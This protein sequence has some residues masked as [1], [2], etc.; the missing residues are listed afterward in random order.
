MKRLL[1]VAASMMLAF[2]AYAG[3]L[4]DERRDELDHLLRH[5]CGS[6][7]GLRL[8][9]GLGPPLT[10]TRMRDRSTESLRAAIRDGIPGTA[11]PPW[12]PLLSDPDIAY[13]ADVLQGENQ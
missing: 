4:D 1:L 11:M 13:L 7:H 5:D 8:E 6:C 12:G 3:G 9:G 10:P 2:S